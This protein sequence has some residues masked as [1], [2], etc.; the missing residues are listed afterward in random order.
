MSVPHRHPAWLRLADTVI[1][2]LSVS[3][4]RKDWLLPTTPAPTP[5]L[6]SE[7]LEFPVLNNQGSS[8]DPLAKVPRGP[9]RHS[10]P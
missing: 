4:W 8:Q 7:K 6:L 2:N 1:E 5:A 3:W 9:E 10:V